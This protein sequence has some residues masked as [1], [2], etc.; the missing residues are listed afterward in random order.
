MRAK[1]FYVLRF[2]QGEPEWERFEAGTFSPAEPPVGDPGLPVVALIPDRYFFFHLPRGLAVR[3]ERRQKS[4]TELRLSQIFPPPGPGQERGAL[5]PGPAGMPGFF[6]HPGLAEFWEQ[7]R[8]LLDQATLVTTSFVLAWHWAQ[9]RGLGEWTL[10]GGNGDGPLALY[11]EDGLHYLHDAA[12]KAAELAAAGAAPAPAIDWREILASIGEPGLAWSKLR[13]PLRGFGAG[14]ISLRPYVH[15]VV[16]LTLAALL[17]YTGPVRQIVAFGRGAD[18]WKQA[19]NGL[20]AKA[21]GSD[22]GR[23]PFGSLAAKLERL[24]GRQGGS[25]D[26][27]EFLAAL[28]APAPDGLEVE[29]VTLSSRTGA[30]SGKAGNYESLQAYLKSLPKDGPFGFTLEQATNMPGGVGFSL[31]VEPMA[32]GGR[33]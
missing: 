6:T 21:L 33:P 25:A 8:G 12:R 4:A 22:I 28:S 5:A 29:T 30:V 16:G 24:K 31:K 19:L 27:L 10:P 23:D 14:R 9:A 13:I 18:A 20:Y 17:L 11:G 15:A 2:P 1:R 32:P 7:R 26:L 3:G